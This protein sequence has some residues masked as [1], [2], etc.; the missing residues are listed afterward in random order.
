MRAKH[1][2]QQIMGGAHVGHPVAHGLVDRVLQRAAAGFD[3][4]H[5]GAQQAHAVN[6]QPLPLHVRSAHVHDAF[7]SKSRRHRSRGHAVLP[8]AGLRDHAALAHAHRQQTLPQAI[9]NFV[10]AGMQQVF[11]LQINPRTAQMRRQPLRKL[12]WSGPPRK[13]VQQEIEFALES[14]VRLRLGVRALELLERSHQRLRHVPPAVR[15]EAPAHVRPR[16]SGFR[17]GLG[18]RHR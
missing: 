9:V 1:R 16:G 14:R 2:A 5:F 8:R 12:Q 4:H 6:I 10:R 13:I 17:R 7:Q 3:A 18:S 15:A 11:A